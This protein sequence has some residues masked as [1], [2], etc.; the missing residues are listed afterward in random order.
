M[1]DESRVSEAGICSVGRQQV[2]SPHDGARNLRDNDFLES[3]RAALAILT[4]KVQPPFQSP[5]FVLDGVELHRNVV[6]I[7]GVENA[8]LLSVTAIGYEPLRRGS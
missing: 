1:Y 8:D 5:W 7:R 4:K 6:Q 2:T 3:K